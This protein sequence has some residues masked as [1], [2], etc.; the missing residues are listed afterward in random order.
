VASDFSSVDVEINFVY[1]PRYMKLNWGI[2]PSRIPLYRCLVWCCTI[3]TI[4]PGVEVGSADE[5][6]HGISIAISP[7]I[8]TKDSGISAGRGCWDRRFKT[9]VSHQNRHCCIYSSSFNPNLPAFLP[10]LAADYSEK[11]RVSGI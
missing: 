2:S 5:E 7:G 9:N 10:N 1:S 3:R 4:A 6:I 11:I 8:K